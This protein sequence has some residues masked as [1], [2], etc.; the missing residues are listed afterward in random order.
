[1]PYR[2]SVFPDLLGGHIQLAFEPVPAVIGYIKAGKLRGLGVSTKSRI[3]V[4]PDLPTIGEFLPGYEATGWL[5][6]GAPAHT[7]PAVVDILNKAV[8]AGLGDPK[9]KER[10][11]NLGVIPEPM[12]I[13]Q[14][15][16]F[17]AAETEKWAKVVQFAHIKVQ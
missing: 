6:V 4:L 10:L 16:A 3:A 7:P 14:F 12:S 15:R 2:E 5:G 1:V 11:L 9:L 17:I 13:A 8:T